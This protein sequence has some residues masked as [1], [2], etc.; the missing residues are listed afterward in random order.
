M[1]FLGYKVLVPPPLKGKTLTVKK[2]DLKDSL[3]FSGVIEAREKV[4]L[5]FQSSGRLTWVGVKEGDR[6]KKFQGIATLDRE[7]LKKTMENYMNTYLKERNSFENTHDTN[8][9]YEVSGN[10]CPER[11]HQKDSA[12]LTI[13]S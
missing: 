7:S 3:S 4:T 12:R 13:R 9:D 8:R 5:K 2:E 6:V 10:E 11:C 1:V